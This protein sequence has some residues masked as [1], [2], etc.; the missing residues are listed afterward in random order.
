MYRNRGKHEHNFSKHDSVE[1][2]CYV[3]HIVASRG[4][5]AT[6]VLEQLPTSFSNHHVLPKTLLIPYYVD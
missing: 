1:T 4:V 5:S 2:H 6:Q 3:G